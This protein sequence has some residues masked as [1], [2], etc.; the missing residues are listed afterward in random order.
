LPFAAGASVLTGTI[1]YWRFEDWTLVQALY[2]CVVT[3]ADGRLRRPLPDHPRD[4][5][6][7]IVYILTG[8][9]VLVARL[10]SVAQEYLRQKAEPG[11][12][13]ARVSARRGRDA[14]V[15]RGPQ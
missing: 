9:G 10:T 4:A 5:D 14:P 15:E 13:R 1:F 3:L 6:F 2:F 12:V 8:F 11:R 7:T